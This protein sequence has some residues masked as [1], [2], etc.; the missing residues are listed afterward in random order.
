MPICNNNN[1]N[2]NINN[3]N[4]LSNIPFLALLP[5]TWQQSLSPVASATHPEP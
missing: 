1:N 5:V 2:S 3:N 4:W